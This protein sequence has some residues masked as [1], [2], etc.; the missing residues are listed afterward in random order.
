MFMVLEHPNEKEQLQKLR[1]GVL[2]ERA[3]F[4]EFTYN[5]TSN[6]TQQDLDCLYK[7]ANRAINESGE[8][9][10]CDFKV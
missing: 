7:Y 10:D 3:K 8:Y 4:L 6:L 5:L 9:T 1:K 2:D